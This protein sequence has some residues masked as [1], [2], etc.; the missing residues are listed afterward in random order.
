MKEK[1]IEALKVVTR[2]RIN[3]H[4]L[5][6]VCTDDKNEASTLVIRG[7]RDELGVE[8]RKPRVR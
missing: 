5:E 7:L 3:I 8:R 4:R 1:R 2:Q 6:V